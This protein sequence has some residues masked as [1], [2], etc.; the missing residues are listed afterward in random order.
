EDA[1]FNA[2]FLL[3]VLADAGFET[4][5]APNGKEAVEKF[6]ASAPGEY[7]VI[8]MDMEMPVMD[9]CEAARTIR[10]MDREDAKTVFIIACTANAFQDDKERAMESGMDDFLTK[11]VDIEKFLKKI[12]EKFRAPKKTGGEQEA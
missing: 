10:A 2:E 9:G 1:E 5:L 6:A 4:T 8:L 3:D 12:R 11:P 7:S